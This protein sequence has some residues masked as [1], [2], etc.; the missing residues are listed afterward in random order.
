MNPKKLKPGLVA[1]YDLRP[2]KGKG[3]LWFRRF[4]NVS[5]TYLFT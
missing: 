5:L 3:L 1:A 2:K 4:I